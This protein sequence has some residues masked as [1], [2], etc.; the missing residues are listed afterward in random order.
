MGIAASADGT[1]WSRLTTDPIISLGPD[2]DATTDPVL[3]LSPD[4]RMLYLYYT[5]S[6][7]GGE[8]S[9]ITAPITFTP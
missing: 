4:A 9:L 7:S 6:G 3:V 1:H 2:A 5:E 8:F